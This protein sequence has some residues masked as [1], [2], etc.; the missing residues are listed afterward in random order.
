[1]L[2]KGSGNK[3][4]VTTPNLEKRSDVSLKKHMPRT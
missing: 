3:E 2:S 1:M 4:D